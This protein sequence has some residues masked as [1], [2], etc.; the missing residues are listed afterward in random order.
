MPM[1][2]GSVIDSELTGAP[3]CAEKFG[4]ART[5]C[6]S[7]PSRMWS[8]MLCMYRPGDIPAQRSKAR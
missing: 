8:R 1:I 3:E 7:A 6:D 4:R 2:Q 5:A